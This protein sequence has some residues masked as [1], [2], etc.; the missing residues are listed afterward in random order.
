MKYLLNLHETIISNSIQKECW[1]VCCQW[2]NWIKSSEITKVS[3]S[4][5]NATV[6]DA[7]SF[8]GNTE[9]KTNI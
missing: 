1:I 5:K 4:K 7:T 6:Q 9:N 8:N 2:Y 3:E